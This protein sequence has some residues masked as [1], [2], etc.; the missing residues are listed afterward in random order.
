MRSYTAKVMI[1]LPGAESLIAMHSLSS[2]RAGGDKSN[3]A[4]KIRLGVMVQNVLNLY[5]FNIF[6]RYIDE[7]FKFPAI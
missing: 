2:L 4:D 7:I 5:L 3:P 6:V 1:P